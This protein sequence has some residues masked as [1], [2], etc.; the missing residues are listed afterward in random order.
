[1]S[2]FVEQKMKR[3]SKEN[4]KEM[5]IKTIGRYGESIVIT[6]IENDKYI[7][8][9]LEVGIED[10]VCSTKE[11]DEILDKYVKT[12]IK[13]FDKDNKSLLMSRALNL[14]HKLR[15]EYSFFKRHNDDYEK[16][17]TSFIIHQTLIDSLILQLN[18]KQYVDWFITCGGKEDK[19]YIELMLSLKD[20]ILK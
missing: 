2:L 11:K 12:G 15:K 16:I 3:Q 10:Y 19:D 20:L 14:G 1:M 9:C 5:A 18:D 13:D 17:L 4:K 6:K 7:I 8:S